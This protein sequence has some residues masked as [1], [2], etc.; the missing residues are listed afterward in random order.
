MQLLTARQAADVL[1]IN[2]N[3]LNAL[4][5]TGQ[6]PHLRLP[7]IVGDGPQFRFNTFDIAAWLKQ[8]PTLAIND[9]ASMER[10]SR[11][12]ESQYPG[13]L[14]RL[15]QFDKQFIAPRRPKGY[16]LS[17]VAN[18]KLGFVY[19]V[20]YIEKGKLVP[21]RW[22]TH[23]NDMDAAIQF[24]VSN[25]D[26]LLSG[27]GQRKAG[28]KKSGSMYGIMR[29]YYEKNSPYLKNDMLR[30]RTLGEDTRKTYHNTILNH[31]VP[32]LKK[33][34]IRTF[35]EIDTPLLARFQDYCLGKGNRPQTVNHYVSFVSNIFDHLLVRGRIQSNPCR[36]VRALKVGKGEQ[37]VTGCYDLIKMKGVFNKRWGDQLSYL[38]CLL[39][40]TTDMRNCE[41]E[42]IQVKDLMTIKDIHFINIPKSK[43]RN[44][45]RVVPLHNFV[46]R[47]L[48]A[49]VHRNHKGHEDFVFKLGKRKRLG[50]RVYRK[51]YMELAKHTG[52]SI[53]RIEKENIK[54]YSGRHF[55]KTL[56]NAHDLGEVEEYFMGHKVSSDVAKRYNHR[57]KQGQDKIVVKAR[58]VFAILDRYLL[59]PR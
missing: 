9:Q 36:S 51:A 5:N 44:G 39:I 14:A 57:D 1:H 11:R 56:M 26:R 59:T 58:E 23:T 50:S 16:S 27:Y 29:Q 17:K 30:G 20:R 48:M 6:I 37:K 19:Y 42:R 46:Y 45:E 7:G 49:Y 12:I 10:F 41:I 21:S 32:F 2:E 24:A 34:R 31:W 18:K 35:D 15:R 25:R 40:Y 33:H 22:S 43:T 28:A 47:K 4:A 52:Y 38:L 53:E 13:E 3:T 8:G 55:W 54:F